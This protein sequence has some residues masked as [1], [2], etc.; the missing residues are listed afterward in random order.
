MVFHWKAEADCN[1]D[2]LVV[3]S[4]EHLILRFESVG[5]VRSGSESAGAVQPGSGSI[6]GVQ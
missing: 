3:A 6:G 4:L 5:A 1:I 2:V